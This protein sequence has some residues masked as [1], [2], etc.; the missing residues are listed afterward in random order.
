MTKTE[1]LR[2]FFLLAY[3]VVIIHS[4]FGARLFGFKSRLFDSLAV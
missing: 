2:E 1:K 4:V 3:D